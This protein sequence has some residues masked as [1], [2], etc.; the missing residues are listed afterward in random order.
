MAVSAQYSVTIRVEL[1]ARQE[2]LGKL[3][4][5]IAEAGGHLQGVDLVPGAGPEG[6]RVR[7]FTIDASDREHW[8]KILRAI[9]STRGARVLDYVDRTMQ[10]H[11]GGK[12]DMHN[13]YPVKTRDDLSMAYT[14]GVARVC[15]DI[16]HD[17]AKAFEYTI[18]KNTVAVVSDGSAVLGLGNIGPEA[19]MPVMEGKCML[20]KEFAG[21]DAFPICLDTQDADEIVKAVEL[22]APTFGGINLEDI[23]APRCFEIEDRLKRSLDIPVFHDDQHGTAVVTMAALFNALKIT[24][25]PIEQLRVLIV[26]LGAAGVAVTKMMLASGITQ[27]VGCDRKGALSTQREDYLSG[28]MNEA[29]RWYAENT[30]PELIQGQPDDVIEAM[31]IFVGLSGP[32]IIKPESLGKMNDDAIVFAMAN[33]TPE[34]MPEEAA[35]YVRIM[36]TGRS[37]Y[38]NQINNVLA[39]PGIFR[40]ALDA[41]AP[42][43]TEEMKLAAAQGIAM[44]VSE[45]DLAEDYIIPSV[46][47]RDV[48]PKVAEAVVEEAKRDGIARLND[49]TGTFA[50]VE[51]G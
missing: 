45:A 31:D 8:E 44:A 25:K 35:P 51:G 42:S 48:A 37:D 50:T 19:A 29:K 40:G 10:M 34:V 39:F 32:G 16:H 33:P 28:A 22:M 13:K 12:I 26:G 46:F 30:N 43:I 1:D 4:A 5:A 14:P 3:T 2:P 20:F 47:N 15:M 6:K 38:A 7:E 24:G 18:K 36:A 41:G 11:R 27:I 9:G 17:R 49:E 23:S 21:V